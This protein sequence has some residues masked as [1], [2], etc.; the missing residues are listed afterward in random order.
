MSNFDK[1]NP[2]AVFQAEWAKW[3]KQLREWRQS[4][5]EWRQVIQQ[6]QEWDEK[7]SKGVH[8]Q[9]ASIDP[10]LDVFAIDNIM[11]IGEGEPLFGSFEYE[12]W[13]LLSTKVELHLLVHHFR[14]DTGGAVLDESNLQHYYKTYFRR[15][16]KLDDFAAKSAAEVIE[17]V[18]DS[19]CIENAL[20]DYKLPEDT[21]FVHFLKMTEKA[22]RDRL[23]ALEAG[24][25]TVLLKFPGAEKEREAKKK[26]E[27][28]KAKESQPPLERKGLAK[29]PH[30]EVGYKDQDR[31]RRPERDRDRPGE[32]LRASNYGQ[33]YS[34]R[35]DK[36]SGRERDMP[37]DRYS[38][39]DRDRRPDRYS[40]RD[41]DRDGYR[42]QSRS[43]DRGR[44]GEADS[45]RYRTGSHA[46]PPS[47]PR[48]AAARCPP[49]PPAPRANTT[50]RR[51][52]PSTAYSRALPDRDRERTP[53]Q[54]APQ[55]AYRR[56]PP[57]DSRSGQR[58]AL[59]TQVYSR[60]AGTYVQSV[61]RPIVPAPPAASPGNSGSSQVKGGKG[62]LRRPAKE[63][64]PLDAFMAGME[65]HGEAFATGELNEP[66]RSRPDPPAAAPQ[67]DPRKGQ[68]VN[69]G[70]HGASHSFRGDPAPERYRSNAS[71]SDVRH[72]DGR[73]RHPGNHGS[74]YRSERSAYPESYRSDA[75]SDSHRD[76]RSDHRPIGSLSERA[77]SSR[78]DSHR[79][80]Y[81]PPSY[82]DS[83]NN[84]S[85]VRS[86]SYRAGYQADGYRDGR[87]QVRDD[88]RNGRSQGADY[89]RPEFGR[90]ADN[91]R[92]DAYRSAPD[93][94]S[95]TSTPSHGQVEDRRTI[96]AR[97][98]YSGRV[99]PQDL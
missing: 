64:D 84:D 83:Y 9:L 6:L 78:N 48:T 92:V 52:P 35:D 42:I 51:D 14:D 90:S 80:S 74:D 96:G 91:Y 59:S 34:S 44:Y 11:D 30:Q 15:E 26:Y 49:P 17:L 27:A 1:V 65:Q 45:R 81:R 8:G 5:D 94:Y 62:H 63:L 20:L 4:Y 40:E 72:S 87:G 56:D 28:R 86:E 32:S 53:A 29:R 18:Q 23:Q 70:D 25:E 43:R 3:Q 85:H 31:E 68:M 98:G 50:T 37:R 38:D 58:S 61:P 77:D 16:L 57:P 21:P 22:R 46:S 13:L 7:E 41:T 36:Q 69:H 73:D 39:R 99:N 79:D 89:S 2:G 95:R 19:V 47:E 10:N 55:T 97:S 33:S 75:R 88:E 76:G 82:R 54:P 12:D 66:K 71:R 93:G 60:D 24:D 67:A